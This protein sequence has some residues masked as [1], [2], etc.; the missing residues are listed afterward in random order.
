MAAITLEDFRLDYPEFDSVADARITRSITKAVVRLGN[1]EAEWGSAYE[2]AT[3]LI[4][5]HLLARSL[6]STN[7]VETQGLGAIALG[8][9]KSISV[10]GE[11]SITYE[12]PP[13]STSSDGGS[14]ASEYLSTR[15][16]KAYLELRRSSIMPARIS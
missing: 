5:A 16:G 14:S 10:Q 13:G 9:A 12:D 4:A 15:Y 8:R 11:G 7:A 6:E 3:G 2:E 1:S